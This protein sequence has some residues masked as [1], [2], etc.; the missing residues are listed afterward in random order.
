[1]KESDPL[2]E[3]LRKMKVITDQLAAIRASIPEHEHIVAL[4]L[5]L[6]RSYNTLVTVLTAKGDELP[7]GQLHQALL[8]EEEKRKQSCVNENNTDGQTAFLHKFER[9]LIKCYGCVE[10][11]QL[12]TE[13]EKTT[14]TKFK[15][16]KI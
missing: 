8:S 15:F 13:K 2:D 4:L 7:L 6:P 5:S 9:K 14:S 12:Y 10:E 16:K 3:H 1:M 11:R